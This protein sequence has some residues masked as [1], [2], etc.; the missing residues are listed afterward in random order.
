MDRAYS[1][2]DIKAVD[3]DQRVIEGI[4]STPSPDRASDIVDP[5]GA[6]FALPMP[7]LWQ[8]RHGEPIGWVEFAKP[9]PKGIPF[10]AR[11]A[12]P[13][14]FESETLKERLREAWD[15]VK[16]KLVRA[17]SIGFKPLEYSYIEGGGVHFKQWEWLELSA[18]T[19]P[20]QA[21]ATINTVKSIVAEARSAA[22]E[23]DEPTPQVSTE[24]EE[25]ASSGKKAHVVKLEAPARD[26]APFVINKINHR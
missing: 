24:P 9:T 3:D 10:K 13:K 16:S 19:I 23:V 12:D 21:D 26:R 6:K 7:L 1:L 11:I 14:D 15:S 2:L 4:A 8:H 25:P 5:M 22:G 17:V 20:M 18:V